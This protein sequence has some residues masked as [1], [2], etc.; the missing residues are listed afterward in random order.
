MRRSFKASQVRIYMNSGTVICI[1]AQVNQGIEVGRD[2]DAKEIGVTDEF[3][4]YVVF[5]IDGVHVEKH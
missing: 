4:N 3:K 1:I 2:K 5:S